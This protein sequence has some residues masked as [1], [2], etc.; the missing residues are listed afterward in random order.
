[1][2]DFPYTNVD[3]ENSFGTNTRNSIYYYKFLVLQL[4]LCLVYM[5]ELKYLAM[6][7]DLMEGFVHR[8]KG[9]L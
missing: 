5:R 9:L 3:E 2:S 7:M 8:K 1:M 6:Q 4:F